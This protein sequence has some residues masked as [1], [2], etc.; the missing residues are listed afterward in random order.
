MIN[1]QLILKKEILE[2]KGI[3]YMNHI[4][5]EFISTIY[6]NHKKLG[7]NIIRN[8]EKKLKKHFPDKKFVLNLVD[9][10]GGYVIYLYT[11]VQ[12]ENDVSGKTTKT[13]SIRELS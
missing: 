4:D 7:E 12:G 5:M 1:C 3:Q 2:N 9:E 13:I 11:E 8:W 6:A 10:G